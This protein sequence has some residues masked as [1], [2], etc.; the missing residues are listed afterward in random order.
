MPQITNSN[1]IVSTTQI[2]D[3]VIVN[4]DINASAA[5]DESKIAFATNDGSR[6]DHSAADIAIGTLVTTRGGTGLSDPTAKG[7]L[8]AQGASAM[9]LIAPG[10]NGQVLK[11]DGTNWGA[12]AVP[13]ALSNYSGSQTSVNPAQNVFGTIRTLTSIPAMTT[14]SHYIFKFHSDNG[15]GGAGKSHRIT[16]GGTALF[17]VSTPVES[18]VDFEVELFAKNSTSAQHFRAKMLGDSTAVLTITVSAPRDSSALRT[19]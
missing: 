16:V 8:R 14:S 9:D 18:N 19:L 2:G 7:L 5:I 11:S 10:S 4:A 1:V 17:S 6:H 15:Q 13:T 3:G 12:G